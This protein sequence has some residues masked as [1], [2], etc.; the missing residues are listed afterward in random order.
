MGKLAQE[1]RW[2]WRGLRK[3][4]AFTVPIVVSLGLAIAG[5]TVIFAFINTLFLLPLPFDRAERLVRIRE[6]HLEPGREP[7]PISVTAK[8][9]AAWQA[10][11]RVFAGLA[12]DR[13]HAFNLSGDG[14]P[15]RI[16]GGA[17]TANFF[18]VVGVE[19]ILGRAIRPQEDRPGS[20]DRVA[21]LS[22]GLW[23]RRFGADR[24]ILGRTLRLDEQPYTVIGVLPPKFRFP[25]QCEFWVPLGL[26]VND[27]GARRLIVFGRLRPAVAAAQ[28]RRELTALAA[29]LA[30]ELPET[31]AGWSV[32]LKPVR[33]DLVGSVRPGLLALVAAACCLLLIA[34]ANAASLLLARG[35]E[36]GGE[37][38]LRVAL[39]ARG[40]RLLL[41]LLSQGLL[42]AA[43][44]GLLG[45]GITAAILA[46][47]SRLSPVADMD[48]FFRSSV[49][50]DT[51]VLGFCLAVAA[52]VGV[53]FGLI[54]ALRVIR[55][56]LAALLKEGGRSSSGRLSRR[57]LG[58][59]VVWELAVAAVLLA[60]AGLMVKELS[61][62]AADRRRLSAQGPGDHA[63]RPARGALPGSCRAGRVLRRAPGPRPGPAGRALRRRHQH[64]PLQRRP[65][66]G[67]TLDRGPAACRAR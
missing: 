52:V 39:G 40:G 30:K 49:T 29:R 18:S 51:R 41:P 21:L 55:P 44:A 20:P 63:D 38:C 59:L 62:P 42:L 3:S 46:P 9:F 26:D 65:A 37:M 15:E 61:K 24:K 32:S 67:S 7:V 11:D 8:N 54:P 34:C 1:L 35:V 27:L 13:P 19:P 10:L 48:Y 25:Y 31:N 16:D 45:L 58:A 57:I 6:V 33:E 28:A 5:N 53:V 56:D 17:V 23:Q 2:A 36:Q 66:R 22:Y 14:D 64:A 47:L 60:G 50:V 43:M 12:A 4:P